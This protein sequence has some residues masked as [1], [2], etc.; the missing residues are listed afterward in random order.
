MAGSPTPE[1][2]TTAG[3]TRLVRA[4]GREPYER[5]TLYNIVNVPPAEAPEAA[6][7]VV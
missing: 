7:H 3:L 4:A 5:D 1:G 6:A 2:M